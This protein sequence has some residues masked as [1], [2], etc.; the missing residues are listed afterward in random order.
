MLGKKTDILGFET[1]QMSQRAAPG[2][3][4]INDPLLLK[5]ILGAPNTPNRRERL[6]SQRN[7]TL[8]LANSA[9][10]IQ[11]RVYRENEKMIGPGGLAALPSGGL[12]GRLFSGKA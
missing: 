12:L 6:I 5:P 8:A 7:T 9:Q 2:N 1:Q 3:R 4:F 11:V 10:G